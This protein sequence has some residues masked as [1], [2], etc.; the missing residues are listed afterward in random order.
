M[1]L[2]AVLPPGCPEGLQRGLPQEP[3]QV[4]HRGVG[5]SLPVPLGGVGP[6]LPVQSGVGPYPP[7]N[8]LGG[9]LLK[10]ITTKMR[11]IPTCAFVTHF[12]DTSFMV[13]TTVL[14]SY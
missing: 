11:L 14:L 3:R 2:D 13:F 5:P 10:S 1:Y 8:H 9:L 4:R 7:L 12:L 6:S